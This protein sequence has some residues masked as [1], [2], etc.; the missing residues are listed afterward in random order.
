VSL[1]VF[2]LLVAV[3]V[4]FF[5]VMVGDFGSLLVTAAEVVFLKH[6]LLSI[7]QLSCFFN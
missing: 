2:L 5:L 6:I 1:L 4:V 3:F 7:T